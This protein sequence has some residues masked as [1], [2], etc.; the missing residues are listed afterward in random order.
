M[1]CP[2]RDIKCQH[3]VR[4]LFKL[5]R[6]H[7]IHFIPKANK[8][9][10]QLDCLSLSKV[11]WVMDLKFKKNVNSE[12]FRCTF[13][14]AQYEHRLIFNATIPTK[15]LLQILMNLY[16]TISFR[17]SQ[18]DQGQ[19]TFVHK[20]KKTNFFSDSPNQGRSN[21]D[22]QTTFFFMCNFPTQKFALL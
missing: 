4:I 21:E 20:R 13:L 22:N 7:F 9:K 5:Y 3:H 12:P 18:N 14:I 11:G 16:Q 8:N 19:Y 2:L 10:K 15:I 6:V 1:S 17:N